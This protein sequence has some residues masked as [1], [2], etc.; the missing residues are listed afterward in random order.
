MSVSEPIPILIIS[1]S[2]A[3]Q[4]AIELRDRVNYLITTYG[5]HSHCETWDDFF[6]NSARGRNQSFWDLLYMKSQEM[7]KVRGYVVALWTFDDQAI[8]REQYCKVARGNVV[9]EFGLFYGALGPDYV[10]YFTEKNSHPYTPTYIPTDLAGIRYDDI[11][12]SIDINNAANTILN[13]LI[14]DPRTNSV[15]LDSK[16]DS[17]PSSEK[18]PLIEDVSNYNV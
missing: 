3:L 15:G 6:K 7:K 9:L 2:E 16:P 10:F 12:D 17:L 13:R 11:K 14:K 8:I 4:I 18:N 1:S 5:F